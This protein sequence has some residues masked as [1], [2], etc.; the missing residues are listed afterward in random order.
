LFQQRKI[1]PPREAII[2]LL[3]DRIGYTEYEELTGIEK[4]EKD[5]I[6]PFSVMLPAALRRKNLAK[7]CN[8]LGI[9]RRLL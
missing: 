2:E 9:L 5:K 7:Y 6:G 3:E 8:R 1:S 4:H